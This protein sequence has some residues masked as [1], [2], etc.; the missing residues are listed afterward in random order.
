MVKSIIKKNS[1]T[2]KVNSKVNFKKSPI[3][4]N[5]YSPDLPRTVTEEKDNYDQYAENVKYAKKQSLALRKPVELP[6]WEL[7]ENGKYTHNLDLPS[8]EVLSRDL[9]YLEEN[10]HKGQGEWG[11]HQVNDTYVN[12]EVTQKYIEEQEIENKKKEEYAER[13][14]R[15]AAEREAAERAAAERAAAERAAARREA[16]KNDDY[17]GGKSKKSKKSRKSRKSRKSSRRNR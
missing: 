16:A 8:G 10:G 5:R 11:T 7:M 13:K 4:I 17:F 9:A 2:K 12:P 3:S 6:E 15:A 14:K 1:V